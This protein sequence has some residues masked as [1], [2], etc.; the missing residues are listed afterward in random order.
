[1]SDKTATDRLRELLDERGV[2]YYDH[3]TGV[4]WRFWV[5]WSDSVGNYTKSVGVDEDGTCYAILEHLT[6]EQAI[7][8]TVGS[9]RLAFLE[10]KVKLQG[11]YIDK[12]TKEKNAI[13]AQG[14]E[15]ATRHAGQIDAMQ[16]KLNATLGRGTCRNVS[17]TGNFRCSECDAVD[18][19][20]DKPTYCHGCG[21]KVVD[22]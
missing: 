17:T 8:A 3:A 20:F 9:D 16:R 11:D 2:E 10:E 6:P 18:L 7:A 22:E 1:V 5:D 19:D 13:F 12:L 21:R 4:G 15:A 14:C